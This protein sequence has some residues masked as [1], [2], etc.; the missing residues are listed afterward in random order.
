[1]RAEMAPTNKNM[2]PRLRMRN[3]HTIFQFGSTDKAARNALPILYYE[4]Q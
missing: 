2:E 1:M 4:S 3:L